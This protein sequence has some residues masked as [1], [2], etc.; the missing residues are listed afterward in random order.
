MDSSVLR[1]HIFVKNA[2]IV[3]NPYYIEPKEV[4]TMSRNQT[5]NATTNTTQKKEETAIVNV[6]TEEKTGGLK[7]YFAKKWN[8]FVEDWDDKTGLEKAWFIG[9]RVLA[10]GGAYVLGRKLLDD[11]HH[12][13]SDDSDEVFIEADGTVDDTCEDDTIIE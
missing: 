5:K 1:D 9:K 7:N 10:I 2:R 3:M 13:E 6:N 8:K 12:D 4:E 11:H